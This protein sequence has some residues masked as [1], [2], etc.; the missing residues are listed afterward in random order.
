MFAQLLLAPLVLWLSLSLLI[1]IAFVKLPHVNLFALLSF[2]RLLARVRLAGSA[3]SPVEF[4]PASE[5]ISEWK[6]IS[7]SWRR[8][9]EPLR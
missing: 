5:R 7:S 9:L 3:S 1:G 6:L 8:W 4:L 2:T